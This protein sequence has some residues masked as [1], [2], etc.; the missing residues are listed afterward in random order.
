MQGN[1]YLILLVSIYIL[2]GFVVCLY[3]SR[4]HSID[5]YFSV[6]ARAIRRQNFIG[7]PISLEHVLR[8]AFVDDSKERKGPPVVRQI[9]VYYDVKTAWKP[10]IN[11]NINFYQIPHCFKFTKV[12]AISLLFY[13]VVAIGC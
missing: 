12:I 2:L 8:N 6:L 7:S 1:F 13:F 11:T 3:H 5:Q 9:V 10:Y 4:F